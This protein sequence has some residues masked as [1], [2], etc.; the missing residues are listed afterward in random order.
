MLDIASYGLIPIRNPLKRR[1]PKMFYFFVGVN[2]FEILFWCRLCIG[3]MCGFQNKYDIL[4]EM[5]KV[6]LF[7]Y[8]CLNYMLRNNTSEKE[9]WFHHINCMPST[10]M[11]FL[12]SHAPLRGKV[13]LVTI[14][15]LKCKEAY[16]ISISW[17]T[18]CWNPARLLLALHRVLEIGHANIKEQLEEII[19]Y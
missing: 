9:S 10:Q 5:F 6:Y 17:H 13:F 7:P 18:H 11:Y 12:S 14:M 16:C 19:E 1:I 2:K 15:I 8:R 3:R 4:F